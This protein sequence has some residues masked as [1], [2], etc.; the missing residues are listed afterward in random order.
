MNFR[1]SNA[2]RIRYTFITGER[3][4]EALYQSARAGN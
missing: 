1:V 4:I 3:W 2:A